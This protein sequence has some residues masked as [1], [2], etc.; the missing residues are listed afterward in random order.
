VDLEKKMHCVEMFTLL[1]SRGQ[2]VLSRLSVTASVN[3][4]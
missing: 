4:E 1:L 2:K 3:V